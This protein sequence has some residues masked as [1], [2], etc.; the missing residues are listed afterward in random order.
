MKH[1]PRL[2]LNRIATAS[3]RTKP[4][5]RVTS[6]EEDVQQ[7]KRG[8][9]VDPAVPFGTNLVILFNKEYVDF[10]RK[11]GV[12]YIP[13]EWPGQ[14][15]HKLVPTSWNNKPTRAMPISSYALSV[16]AQPMKIRHKQTGLIIRKCIPKFGPAW[17]VTY[18]IGG[19]RNVL[20][21]LIHATKAKVPKRAIDKLTSEECDQ[22][23]NQIVRAS[24]LR[25]ALKGRKA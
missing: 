23:Y 17:K 10:V 1:T 6:I 11:E 16:C 2:R 7:Y 4:I 12:N 20:R 3:H 25:R 9:H 8:L 14:A 13:V 24:R 15:T 19:K 21:F 22:L 18:E 5:E